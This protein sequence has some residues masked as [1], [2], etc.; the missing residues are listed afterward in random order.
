MEITPT[1][2]LAEIITAKP[3][4]SR[5]LDRIGLDYCCHGQRSLEDASRAAG[6]DPATVVAEL[7][8]AGSDA[9]PAPDWA[10]FGPA[11]L[12][13]HVECTHHAYLHAEMPRL[14][15]LALKV[16]DV[17]GGRHPE[18]AEVAR[19]YL[20]LKAEL[21]PHLRTEEQVVFPAIR[22]LDGAAEADGP[23]PVL[24]QPISKLL[25]E[26]DRAGELLEDLR[27]L[28]GGY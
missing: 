19:V 18:L 26:H 6:L 4:L 15:A 5:E 13:D 14:E 21:E 23:V 27:R 8:A 2:T 7:N 16:R 25:S 11:E 3:V 9:E 22:V 24:A 12:A 10:T 17:H 1:A 28:T 20:E